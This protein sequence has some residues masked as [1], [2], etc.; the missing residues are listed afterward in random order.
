MEEHKNLPNELSQCE[1]PRSVEFERKRIEELKAR[2]RKKEALAQ[3]AVEE[4]EVTTLIADEASRQLRATLKTAPTG[5]DT[6]LEA[7]QTDPSAK[8]NLK[9]LENAEGYLQKMLR[10]FQ[11]WTSFQLSSTEK[12]RDDMRNL[13]PIAETVASQAAEE[14][15][16]E[17]K[18]RLLAFCDRL[19]GRVASTENETIE[20]R[21]QLLKQSEEFARLSEAISKTSNEL[22]RYLEQTGRGI[23]PAGKDDK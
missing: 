5:Y 14:T 21:R 10:G 2:V 9:A 23:W 12:L 11:D 22:I 17:M 16:P 19:K 18:Q 1:T 6:L 15:D 3:Q 7:L 20:I 13:L 4:L 8:A